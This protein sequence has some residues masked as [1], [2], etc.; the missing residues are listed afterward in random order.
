MSG[1]G[2]FSDDFYLNMN[3]GT[4]MDLPQNRDTVLHFFEQLQRRY[5]TMRNFYSRERAEY[6]L[7]E[8]KEGGAYRWASIEQRRI[9]SGSVNPESF[10]EAIEQHRTVLELAPYT[11]SVS[12]L[13]CEALNLMFGFDYNYRGNHSELMAEALGMLPG[14]E[15]LLDIPG[16]TLLCHEP[17]IQ[18]ALDD[19][20]RTQCRISFE[21]RTSAYQVRMGEFAEDQLSVYLTLRRYDSLNAGEEYASELMRLAG[22]CRDLV[23]DYLI[24]NILRPLQQ[25]IALK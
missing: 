1:Y 23:D 10:E 5:P 22:L 17:S 3:L 6:V 12:P 21:T 18:F 24:E 11:L 14:F 16:T 8:D 15:K 13:D 4:E 2:A 20:C 7:E 25:T 19:E 9:N